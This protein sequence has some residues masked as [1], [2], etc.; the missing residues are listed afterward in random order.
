MRRV[1]CSEEIETRPWARVIMESVKENTMSYP[2]A[3]LPYREN[4]YCWIGPLLEDTYVF[5]VL[6]SNHTFFKSIND[7]RGLPVGVNRGAP[8]AVRLEKLGFSHLQIAN[9]ENI[10][11]R[12]LFKERITAWYSSKL[13]IQH[14]LRNSEFDE[15]KVRFAFSDIGVKMYI[16]ASPNLKNKA[17]EWQKALDEMKSDGTYLT[18]L[19]KNGVDEN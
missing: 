12:M 1:G 11:P 18:I 17:I 7:F 16:A 8:T 5:A 15:D 19:K 9:E 4:K 10:N 14:T 13:I 6:S 3:R 2:L